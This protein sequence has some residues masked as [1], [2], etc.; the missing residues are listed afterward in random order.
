DEPVFSAVELSGASYYIASDSD[1][2]ITAFEV[3]AEAAKIT[4]RNNSGSAQTVDELVIYGDAAKPIYREPI[5]VIEHDADSVEKYGEL[6][7]PSRDEP[8]RNDYI[9]SPTAAVGIALRILNDYKDF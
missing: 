6:W 8:M 2:V 5:N 9:Q 7:Y 3:F 4:F 1:V